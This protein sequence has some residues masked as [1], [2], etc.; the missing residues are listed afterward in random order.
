MPY[1]LKPFYINANDIAYL[2]AQVN[3]NPLFDGGGN[4]VVNWDGVGTVYSA[5]NQ[6]IVGGAAA[7][8]A[9]ALA[10]IEANGVGF[11]NVSAPIGIRDVSGFHNNLYGT[12]AQWGAV[13]EAFVRLAPADY[14]NYLTTPGADYSVISASNNITDWMPRIISRTITTGGVNLLSDVRR[15]FCSVG[16]SGLY[17]RQCLCAAH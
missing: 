6:A 1:D 3:F 5:T 14:S 12:Q 2:L 8:D 10:A 13:G 11:P 17:S 9:L 4:A 15:S 16:S 7:G